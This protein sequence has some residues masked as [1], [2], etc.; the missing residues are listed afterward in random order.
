MLGGRVAS[1]AAANGAISKAVDLA[2]IQNTTPVDTA[3][4]YPRKSVQPRQAR[5]PAEGSIALRDQLVSEL[6]QFKEPGSLIEW[7]HRALPLKNQLS[8]IDAQAVEKAFDAKLTQLE[9]AAPAV[10]LKSQKSSDHDGG[11]ERGEQGAQAV[12]LISK[13]VRERDREHLKCVAAQS[14]LVCGRTPSDPH[15]IKFAEQRAMGRK[16]SDKFTVPLCRLHHRELHRRGNERAWWQKQGIEPLA[17]AAALWKK[18]HV[19]EA[20]SNGSSEVDP[21]NKA[22]GRHFGN[23]ATTSRSHQRDKT[24]PI[25]GPELQ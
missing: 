15:H 7:A 3:R 10:Q 21:P 9:E 11:L 2:P 23:A 4:A 20:I 25:L 5:L 19:V 24:N 14:C 18:T 6:E 1:A 17:V 13:P 8:I 12:L 16:V 22:N